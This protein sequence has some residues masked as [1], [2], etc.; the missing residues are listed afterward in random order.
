MAN[1]CGD[2][3]YLQP[4]SFQLV[5]DRTN[6]PNLE[7]YVNGVT[8]SGVTLASTQQAFRH[9]QNVPFPGDALQFEEVTFEMILDEDL[10]GYTEMYD[11]INRLALRKFATPSEEKGSVLSSEEDI[12]LLIYTSSNTVNRRISY[13]NAF[14]VSLGGIE[15]RTTET[16]AAVITVP[17]TFAFTYFEIETA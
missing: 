17:I 7:Y 6:Y 1:Q 11:W 14:P 13:K 10:Q 5:I 4:T 3:N 16:E 8:H 15:F 12:S 9:I 2:R